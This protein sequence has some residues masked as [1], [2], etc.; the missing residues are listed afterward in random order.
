VE[1][2]GGHERKGH[3]M[4]RAE[5]TLMGNKGFLW[6]SILHVPPSRELYSV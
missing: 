1:A 2:V 3:M 5:S 4:G 6:H